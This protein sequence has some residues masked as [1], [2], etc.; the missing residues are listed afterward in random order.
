MCTVTFKTRKNVQ[1]D[2][3]VLA[4]LRIVQ[5]LLRFPYFYQTYAVHVFTVLGL[6]DLSAY[7]SPKIHPRL[8]FH[9]SFNACGVMARYVKISTS[10]APG[11]IWRWEASKKEIS[12][13]IFQLLKLFEI[14]QQ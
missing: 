5:S 2:S 1:T 8:L 4:K 14:S 7:T 12:S 13:S 6:R 9:Q 3:K 10:F 11:F